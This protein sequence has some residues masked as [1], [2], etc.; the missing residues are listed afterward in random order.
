MNYFLLFRRIYAIYDKCYGKTLTTRQIFSY[1]QRAV[2]LSDCKLRFV[3]TL[4]VP[5]NYF[6]VSGMYDPEL[7]EE[8]KIS[9]LLEIAFPAKSGT[10]TFNDSDLSRHH[11][12]TLSLDFASILGHEYMHLNQAR[13]RNFKEPRGYISSHTH[14]RMQAIQEYYGDPDEIDAYAFTAAAQLA[15]RLI[16][17]SKISKFEETGVFFAYCRA[18][19]KNSQIILKLKKLT[20]RYLNRLE[21]QYH[22]TWQ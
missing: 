14:T 17:D 15:N 7:D 16:T 21:Q 9:I 10:F 12:L 1:L 22:A 18:F 4:K 6:E 13:A 2:S 20:Q 8:G 11:W 19:D 5:D 3:S